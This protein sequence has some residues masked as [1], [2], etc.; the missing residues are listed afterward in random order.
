MF[1]VMDSLGYTSQQR[2]E[3]TNNFRADLVSPAIHAYLPVWVVYGR[4]PH[5]WE[6]KAQ[7]GGDSGEG[8]KVEG[9]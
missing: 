6:G 8:V 2:E 9:Q 1:R 3:L 5:E 4:K 7:P